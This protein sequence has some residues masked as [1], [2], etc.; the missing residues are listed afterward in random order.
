MLV[1]HLQGDPI[2]VVGMFGFS[3]LFSVVDNL[4]NFRRE[5]VLPATYADNWEIV[6]ASLRP[7]LQLLPGLDEFLQT[8]RL[9][10]AVDKCW[11]RGL[12]PADRKTLRNQEF[13]GGNLPV[14]LTAKSLGADISYCFGSAVKT[15]NSRVRTGGKRLVR[16]VGLPL[17]F[18]HR[19]AVVR[20]S[21]WKHTLHGCQTVAVPKTVR[22]KLRTKLC[23]GLR[24]DRAGRSPWLVSNTLTAEPVDP[25]WTVLVERFRLCRQLARNSREWQSIAV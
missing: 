5:Q 2:S 18:W 20:K 19:V 21:I 3:Y 17:S 12:H 7:L 23:R 15:R 22:T 11:G 13:A 25:E 10:V 16:I 9:P 24:L 1:G 14:L 4:S 6:C 8:C